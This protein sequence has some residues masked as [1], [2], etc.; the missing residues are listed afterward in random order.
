MKRSKKWQQPANLPGFGRLLPAFL[1][2]V[3]EKNSVA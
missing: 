2:E 1:T 3:D